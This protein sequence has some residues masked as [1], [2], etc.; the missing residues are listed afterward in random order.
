MLIEREGRV[1]ED[2]EPT[3]YWGG[4]DDGVVKNEGAMKV[5]ITSSRKMDQF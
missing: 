1:E 2:S 4:R 3:D 5:G